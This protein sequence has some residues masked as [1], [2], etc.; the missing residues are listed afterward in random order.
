MNVAVDQYF[1]ALYGGIGI[2]ATSD[3]QGGFSWKNHLDLAYAYHLKVTQNLY[4]NFA[5][6]AGYYRRD[7]HWGYL[8]FFDNYNQP[9]PPEDYQHSAN[10]AAG[11]IIYNHWMYGGVASH[12][13]SEPKASS[14]S[15][16]V[17]PRKHTAH[18]G[19][20]LTPSQRR[21]ANTLL[22]D[23]F[24]SP[25]IIFQNQGQFYRINYGV[26]FG[27]ES[28]MAG[29][30]YRQFFD[31]PG[32][33]VFLAGVSVGDYRIGYSYDYTLSSFAWANHGV[34]EISVTFN[35]FPLR[36]RVIRAPSYL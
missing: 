35:L 2:I 34:H 31:H 14:L 4:V 16:D 28:L 9:P 32:T 33:M 3:Y 8:D 22:F 17:L 1:P 27:I 23:Y 36:E 7:V 5:L 20:Y 29:V 10:F 19:L 21:R 18:F 15:S 26:Y 12:H 24:I 30:W 11:F 25:N 13:L 6:Q